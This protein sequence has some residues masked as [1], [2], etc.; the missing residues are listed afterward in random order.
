MTAPPGIS[1]SDPRYD[2]RYQSA[3]GA[4][5]LG[6]AIFLVVV[7]ALFIVGLIG[8]VVVRLRAPEWPPPGTPPFFYGLWISTGIL[9]TS[10]VFLHMAYV[11]VRSDNQPGLRRGMTVAALLGV[12]FLLCQAWNWSHMV[13][14]SVTPSGNLYGFTFFMLTGLHALHVLGGVIQLSIAAARARRGK[15]SSTFY[16][17]VLYSAMYWHFLAVIWIVV[18]SILALGG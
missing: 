4:G 11:A 14:E 1:D 3:A 8:Y 18:F 17:G 15:Y 9:V 6:M 13:G 5:K 16:P 7:G 12:A 2:S 10:S